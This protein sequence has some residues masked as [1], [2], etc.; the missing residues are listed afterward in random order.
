LK[1]IDLTKRTVAVNLAGIDEAMKT[2]KVGGKGNQ[3]SE[4]HPVDRVKDVMPSA[5]IAGT[6]LSTRRRHQDHQDWRRKD[7]L[8]EVPAPA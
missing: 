6:S 1:I 8:I 4:E 7:A 5:K 2:G 3:I